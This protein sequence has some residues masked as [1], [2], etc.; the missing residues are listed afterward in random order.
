MRRGQGVSQVRCPGSGGSSPKVRT[1][2]EWGW[3]G[4]PRDRLALGQEGV[5]QWCE[6]KEA[7]GDAWLGARSR[8][9]VLPALRARRG[10][11]RLGFVRAPAG[12]RPW[13][14]PCHPSPRPSP[15][16]DL[17][18][19]PGRGP[20]AGRAT[21]RRAPGEPLPSAPSSGR[22]SFPQKAGTRPA[23]QVAAGRPASPT[24]ARRRPDPSGWIPAAARPAARPRQRFPDNGAGAGAGGGRNTQHVGCP[25]ASPGPSALRIPSQPAPPRS[26][27]GRKPQPC[28]LNGRGPTRL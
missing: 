5:A 3:R 25:S 18:R 22:T 8:G 10:R 24:P 4:E 14:G 11:A 6:V 28:R 26:K 15:P 17:S 13:L 27:L 9:E 20:A 21:G 2:W 1:G 16:A 12:S 7:N 23:A 19:R